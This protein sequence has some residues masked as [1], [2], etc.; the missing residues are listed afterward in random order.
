MLRGSVLKNMNN[1]RRWRRVV[2]DEKKESLRELKE[3]QMLGYYN[4]TRFPLHFNDKWF[5]SDRIKGFLEIF[6][7]IYNNHR[8]SKPIPL[9]L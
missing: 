8:L 9:E 7:G 6:Q 1:L 4:V 2:S 3:S 5:T